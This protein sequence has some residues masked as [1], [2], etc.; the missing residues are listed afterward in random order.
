MRMEGRCVLL[1]LTEK[2]VGTTTKGLLFR[3]CLAKSEWPALDTSLSDKQQTS[4]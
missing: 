2:D 3:R 1:W 4:E